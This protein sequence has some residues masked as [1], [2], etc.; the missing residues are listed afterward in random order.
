MAEV[1]LEDARFFYAPAGP[2]YGPGFCSIFY[3]SPRAISC[4][5]EPRLVEDPMQSTYKLYICIIHIL[6]TGAVN[7]A[8]AKTH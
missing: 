1:V 2:G 7:V 8:H 5:C 6:L 3:G 4:Q